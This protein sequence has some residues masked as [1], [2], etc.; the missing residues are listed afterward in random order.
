MKLKARGWKHKKQSMK[1]L[2]IVGFKRETLGSKSAKDLRN[3]AYAP[4]VLYGGS[5]NVHFYAPMFLFRD[6]L[7]S[8]NVY[9][10]ALNIEGTV[11]RAVLQDSQFHPV[12]DV[13]LH[14]D[15]LE[16]NDSKVIRLDV[17]VKFVGTSKGVLA[18]GKL[19][20]KLRKITL[21]GTVNDMPDFVEVD[22]SHLDLGKSVKVGEVSV[23]G[24]VILNSV[25]NP[26]ATIEIPRAL[27][28]KTAQ[29]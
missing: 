28:G 22:I 15:F 25:S 19:L 20:A 9:E 10:V 29:A 21:K 12:N 11:Y 8:N 24:C 7:Y 18:G 14:V 4:C 13:L 3:E 27:R 26:I 6:L 16:V 23:D 2:E 1:K 17:P 5:E